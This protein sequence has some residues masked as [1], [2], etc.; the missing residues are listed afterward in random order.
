MMMTTTMMMTMMTIPG[1][2]STLIN[3]FVYFHHTVLIKG[4]DLL[5]QLLKIFGNHDSQ[6]Y[7]D[8]FV[9]FWNMKAKNHT[10]LQMHFIYLCSKILGRYRYV[11]AKS[12]VDI[13]TA[14]HLMARKIR[15]QLLII[16]NI[17]SLEKKKKST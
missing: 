5:C 16:I 6:L 10:R 8:I 4:C 3:S 12:P 1:T 17:V 14:E 2:G 13:C 15:K 9:K 7:P 11:P